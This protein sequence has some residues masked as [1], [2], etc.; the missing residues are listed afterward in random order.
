MLIS[1]SKIDHASQD[2]HQHKT[3]YVVRLICP[4]AGEDEIHFNENGAEG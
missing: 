3:E 4:E 2:T 1:L